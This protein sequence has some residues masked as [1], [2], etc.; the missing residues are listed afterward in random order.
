MEEIK[1]GRSSREEDEG[2]GKEEKK[3]DG[4]RE[5]LRAGQTDEGE[6]RQMAI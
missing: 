1:T 2:E 5:E 4:R 6:R 3:R